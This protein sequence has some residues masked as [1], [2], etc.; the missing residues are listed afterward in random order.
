MEIDDRFAVIIIDG[1]D[2]DRRHVLDTEHR[3]CAEFVERR[4]YRTRVRRLPHLFGLFE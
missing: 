4:T 1:N 2:D 3:G